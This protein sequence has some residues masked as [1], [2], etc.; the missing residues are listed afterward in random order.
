MTPLTET[1]RHF[2]ELYHRLSA[3]KRAK[4]LELLETLARVELL[5]RLHKEQIALMRN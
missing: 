1:D 5:A 3:D 4:V 2:L